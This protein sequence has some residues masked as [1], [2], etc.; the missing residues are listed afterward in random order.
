[1]TSSPCAATCLCTDSPFHAFFMGFPWFQHET[2]TC[3]AN[4]S[5]S[6]TA[7]ITFIYT[8]LCINIIH[9]V[10]LGFVGQ[11]QV[12]LVGGPSGWSHPCLFPC[13]APLFVL[14]PTPYHHPLLPHAFS[15]TLPFPFFRSFLS[16][17]PYHHH[18]NFFPFPPHLPPPTSPTTS[19]HTPV[20]LHIPEHG[21]DGWTDKVSKVGQDRT[22]TI[23][24]TT[25][26]NTLR[27]YRAEHLADVTGRA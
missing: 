23:S 7:K 11:F 19:P 24:A 15:L 8:C 18:H 25:A 6:T 2:S 20:P 13:H 27:P 14:L 4:L 10:W 22:T 3:T 17:T 26:V 12:Q 5:L 21:R 16:A 9:T 1:M